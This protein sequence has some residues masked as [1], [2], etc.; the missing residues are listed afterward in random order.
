[1]DSNQGLREL[2]RDDGHL[3]MFNFRVQEAAYL[4]HILDLIKSILVFVSI[5][6]SGIGRGQACR[7]GMA[8]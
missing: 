1:M 6:K 2:D 5:T 3:A 8:T 4:R 7:M